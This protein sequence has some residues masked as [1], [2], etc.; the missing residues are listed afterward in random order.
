MTVILQDMIIREALKPM[1]KVH[2]LAEKT[3]YL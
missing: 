2:L 1:N 3:K